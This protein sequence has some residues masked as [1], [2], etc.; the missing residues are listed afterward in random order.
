M[1]PADRERAAAIV[2]AHFEDP[3]GLAARVLRSRDASAYY[4]LWTALGSACLSPLDRL[5]EPG[6][7]RLYRD[8]PAATRPPLF[9]GGPPRS[10]TTLVFQSLVR[11]FDVS[12]PTNWISMFPRSPIR[13][14]GLRRRPFRN[15]AVALESYYGRTRRGHGTSDAL[16]LWDR[17]LEPDRRRPTTHI[18][19]ER[20]LAMR[21]F[22]GAWDA[23]FDRPLVMKNNSLNTSAARVG[24]ELP[25]SV[26]LILERDPFFLAQ[27]L[28]LA[29][30]AIE[31][32]P[33]RVYGVDDAD[34]PRGAEPVD[35]VA[36]QVA[37]HRRMAAA[38]LAALPGGRA[39]IVGY[40]A[41]CEAPMDALA[42]LGERMGWGPPVRTVPVQEVSARVRLDAATAARLRDALKAADVAV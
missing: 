14:A 26:F 32:D 23:A 42:A 8:A 19:P 4:A 34:R 40:E 11:A 10:G 30:S 38:Q 3:L 28:L 16:H 15:E 29:R 33:Q 35:D 5:L 1:S 21:R 27:A 41:F 39:R 25:E 18:P 20:A 31:G 22:F 24:A 2:P 12:Y 17:W 6:E 13:A 36:F 37:Y 7:Q 9:V